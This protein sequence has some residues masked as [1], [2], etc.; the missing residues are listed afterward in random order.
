[1]ID[2]PRGAYIPTKR[3][4]EK[5]IGGED[6]LSRSTIVLRVLSTAAVIDYGH[7]IRFPFL[8]WGSRPLRP[9][10]SLRLGPGSGALSSGGGTIAEYCK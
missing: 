4:C 7:D 9:S 10:F 8:G 5:I 3:S 2:T 1:M 6:P